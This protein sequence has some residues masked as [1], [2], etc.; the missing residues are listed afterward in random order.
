MAAAP[1]FIGFPRNIIQADAL[2][3]HLKS[4]GRGI[5]NVVYIDVDHHI[6]I[7]RLTGRWVCASC[8]ETF[9]L[10]SNPP[11]IID[12]CDSCNEA[13]IQREDDR[14]ETVKERLRVNDELTKQLEIYYGERG[15]FKKING[16]K[17]I[18]D[19]AKD[20]LSVLKK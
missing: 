3:I 10:I 19:V 6:L 2:E 12:R 8:G 15:N 4:E 1:F 9:H 7:E 5:D 14:E 13:L 17:N 20:I 16:L 11:K 18:N